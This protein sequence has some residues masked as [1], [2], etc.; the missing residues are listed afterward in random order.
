MIMSHTALKVE[1]FLVQ[2]QLVSGRLTSACVWHTHT[3]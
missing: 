1:E 3:L 2:L